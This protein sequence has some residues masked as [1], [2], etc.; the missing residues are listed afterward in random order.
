MSRVR[1]ECIGMGFGCAGL[2]MERAG[3]AAGVVGR[4]VARA[5]SALRRGGA[6]VG[7]M[8]WMT[9]ERALDEGGR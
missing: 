8:P 6:R 3:G 5:L 4:L 2:A 1:I 7:A 9:S